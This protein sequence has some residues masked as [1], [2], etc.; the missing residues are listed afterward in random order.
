MTKHATRG[1]VMALALLA[2]TPW[3]GAEAAEI[4]VLSTV[5]MQ[6]AKQSFAEGRAAAAPVYKAKGLGG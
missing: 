2:L 4:R 1:T 6:P 3:T 5:G